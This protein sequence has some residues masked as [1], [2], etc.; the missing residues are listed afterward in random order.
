MIEEP[1][2]N[3]TELKPN[4]E[5]CTGCGILLQTKSKGDAGYINSR[6]IKQAQ[7]SE[8]LLSESKLIE[9]NEEQHGQDQERTLIKEL[10]EMG[11]P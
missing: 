3:Q 1:I 6:F 4:S 9:E 8:Q 2:I 10:E 7:E 11:A 5:H